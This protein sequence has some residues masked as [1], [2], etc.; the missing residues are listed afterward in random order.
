VGIRYNTIVA[1]DLKPGPR[2]S[3]PFFNYFEDGLKIPTLLILL[4]SSECLI[5]LEDFGEA[6]EL[7]LEAD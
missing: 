1:L 4:T 2:C 7:S 3:G 5:F 6:T